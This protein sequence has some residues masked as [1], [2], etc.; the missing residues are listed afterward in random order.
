[1][2]KYKLFFLQAILTLARKS[3]YSLLIIWQIVLF[4]LYFYVWFAFFVL[5]FSSFFF[6][7]TQ[8]PVVKKV[9]TH[10]V[11]EPPSPLDKSIN[12]AFLFHGLNHKFLDEVAAGGFSTRHCSLNGMFGSAVYFA[13]HSSKANQ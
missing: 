3:L 8:I 11:P 7:R 9:L 1:M 5:S 2:E 10:G 12:E 4:H 6:P 13:E